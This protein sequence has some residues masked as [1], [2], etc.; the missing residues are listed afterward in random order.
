MTPEGSAICIVL[1][2]RG[3][4]AGN[5]PSGH[6]VHIFS[7]FV[8][9]YSKDRQVLSLDTTRFQRGSPSPSD[10]VWARGGKRSRVMPES[11]R[12]FCPT[13]LPVYTS[14]RVHVEESTR[15]PRV[16]LI[17]SV[18]LRSRLRWF[19]E[20]RDLVRFHGG[21]RRELSSPR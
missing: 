13:L 17:V 12:F 5:V 4:V 18:F 6:K 11:T 2:I 8:V 7:C 3:S 21:T 10:I 9:F 1:F 16:C 15:N 14:A 19:E 20:T